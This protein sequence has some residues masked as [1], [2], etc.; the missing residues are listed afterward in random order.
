MYFDQASS[1]VQSARPVINE[2]RVCVC[3]VL[4]QGLVL[5]MGPLL[6]LPSGNLG[7][8]GGHRGAR[9]EVSEAG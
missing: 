7:G 1:P 5:P 9:G 2:S 8:H 3:V 4:G 6:V